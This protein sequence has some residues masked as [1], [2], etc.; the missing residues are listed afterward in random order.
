VAAV[1]AIVAVETSRA[2]TGNTAVRSTAA[3]ARQGGTSS[4][5]S[6][7]TKTTKTTKAKTFLGSYGV[8]SSAIIAENRKPGTTAWKITDAPATGFIEGFAN[9]T[10]ASAGQRVTFY[11]S[12]TAP[13]FDVVAYRMGYYQGKGARAV[14][15]ST[16]IPGTLQPTCPVTAGV[17]MVSCD[18][19]SLSL[20]VSITSAFMQGD[21]LFKLTG[22]DN[23]QSYVLLTVWAPDSTAAYLVMSRSLTEEGWN[24]FGGYSFYEGEGPCTLGQTGSYPPCNRARIVSFD[25]PYATGE[26]ASDFLGNEYPLVRFMEEHGLDVAYCTDV[27]V[28]E[29]PTIL[30]HHRALLSLGHDETWTTTELQ[31]AET[32][33]AH[34]VNIV[35]FGA[36]PAV[37]HARL[38]ASPL[39]PDREEV[40]YRDSTEDPLNGTGHTAT[41]T[42]NT[43]STPPADDPVTLF[44]GSEYSGY[45]DPGVPAAPL[46]VHQA[47]AWLF[48]GTGLQDGSSVP[49]VIE[50]DIDHVNPT[51]APQDL[52]VLAHSPVPLTEVYTN[53]GQWGDDTYVDTTY[54]TDPAGDGGV[55]QS[56]TVNWID[57]LDPCVALGS[58]CPN[59]TLDEITGNLLW[60][61]GQGPAG[62]L[63]PSVSNL[64]TV[65][66]P[67][68]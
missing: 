10:S 19:W 52:E 31:G 24:T 17:N 41:V 62:K 5:R 39:G 32:A 61:F 8:E 25:R 45:L 6:G 23:Q 36:A 46:V 9:T 22:S 21:Y 13:Q 34:G 33:L 35:F 11:V 56:G 67:G 15:R 50:S 43:F 1:V 20:T 57:A 38:Q 40:D 64:D 63:E 42:G 51:A 3:A 7:A 60:L 37:R 55:F 18:N 58:S 66:P 2:T 27:T 49:G 53:Q 65:T 48:K 14:W 47:T 12:T 59:T 4:R 30:L 44:V 26:G 68:S 28:D 16:E 54:Y 29:H